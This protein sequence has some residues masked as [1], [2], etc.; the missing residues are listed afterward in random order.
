MSPHLLNRSPYRQSYTQ[1]ASQLPRRSRVE[2]MRWKFDFGPLSVIVVLLLA[3]V[4]ISFV[5]LAHFNGIATKGYDLKKL[6][7]ERQHLV[8]ENEI[9]SVRLA[10]A[11][12][13]NTMIES[14]RLE[15]MRKVS[16]VIF[17]RVDSA[18]ASR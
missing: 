17:V 4:L 15:G 8:G 2:A 9:K 13:L 11:K 1:Y 16:N 14:G 6:D 7:A 10:E 18:I 12:A 5:Y 3:A